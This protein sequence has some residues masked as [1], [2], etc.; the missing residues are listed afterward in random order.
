MASKSEQSLLLVS[1]LCDF[2]KL[3]YFS[4]TSHKFR[5][6]LKLLSD[7]LFCAVRFFLPVHV[8][9]TNFVYQSVTLPFVA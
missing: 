8:F 5:T 2:D 9:V 4:V 6:R 3:N 7:N 1:E